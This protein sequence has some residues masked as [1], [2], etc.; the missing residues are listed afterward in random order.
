MK[1]RTLDEMISCFNQQVSEMDIK[2]EDKIKL[3][4]M[5]MSI[6]FEAQKHKWIPCSDCERRCEKWEYSKT[7]QE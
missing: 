1:Q 2:H 4:G 6:G 3:L 5:I 7:L